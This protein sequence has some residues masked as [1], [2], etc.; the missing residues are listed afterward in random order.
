MEEF[1]S[2]EILDKEIQE[3]ARRK[4]EKLLKRAD[5]DC[6]K[7]IDDLNERIEVVS[8]EKQ[9]LYAG[10]TE[11]LKKDLDAA[12]PLEKERFLVSFIDSSIIKGINRFIDGLSNEKRIALLENLLKRY[13]SKLVDKK[14]AIKFHG[15]QQDEL[16][17]MFQKHFNKLNIE[18]FVSLNDDAAK[19]LHDEYGMIIESTDKS[20][21]C[22]VTIDELIEEI[23]DT[24]R[25]E[26]AE[27]LFGGRI[28]Q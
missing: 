18:S 26:I 5:D 2:T 15:F 22:R 9:V 13:E 10:R 27:A 11:A 17:K 23:V 14:L 7:I 21:R 20:V 6:Q 3:D 19:E 28:S 12:L 4:A 1:R 8:K 24:Y 25:Y 16:K